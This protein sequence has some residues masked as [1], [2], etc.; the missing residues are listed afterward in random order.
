MTQSTV[1]DKFQTTIPRDVRQALKLSP[2]QKVAYEIQKDG[3]AIIRAVPG[4]D[5]LFGSVRLKRKIATIQEEKAAARRAIASE[6][7]R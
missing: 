5:E 3:S 4:L 1:T 6:G 7:N 2:R